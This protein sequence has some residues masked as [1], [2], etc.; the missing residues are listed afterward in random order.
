MFGKGVE[1]A[2]KNTAEHP[3]RG[4]MR[5][6]FETNVNRKSFV[7]GGK[8]LHFHHRNFLWGTGNLWRPYQ[9]SLI[10]IFYD[11]APAAFCFSRQS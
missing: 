3:K 6:L 1:S 8:R 7:L 10:S 2:V 4:A 5:A 9:R 11:C